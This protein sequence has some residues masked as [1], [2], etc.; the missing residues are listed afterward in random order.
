MALNRVLILPLFMCYCDKLWHQ[1]LEVSPQWLCRYPGAV[2]QILPFQ[3]SADDVLNYPKLDDLPNQHG[4]AVHY[5]E[6]TLM[7]SPKLPERF[8]V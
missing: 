4:A 1:S 5:R 3:C 8:K 2:Q 6:S 7:K